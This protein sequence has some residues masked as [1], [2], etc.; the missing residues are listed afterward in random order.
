MLIVHLHVHVKPESVADFRQ[1]SIE[2]AHSSRRKGRGRRK[3]PLDDRF[4]SRAGL[5]A[6]SKLLSGLIGQFFRQT[7]RV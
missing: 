5:E 1:A 4:P 2:N 3:S 7:I 6:D